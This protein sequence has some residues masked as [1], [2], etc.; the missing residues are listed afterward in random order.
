MTHLSNYIAAIEVV[1][2]CHPTIETTFADQFEIVG[3]L[4]VFS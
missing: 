1:L 2:I 4:N 3:N